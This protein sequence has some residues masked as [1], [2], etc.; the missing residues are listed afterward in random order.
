MTLSKSNRLP[1]KPRPANVSIDGALLDEAKLL[2]INV[3]QACETGLEQQ[4]RKAR[5]EKW[6]E[7][8]REAIEESNKWVEENGLPPGEVSPSSN[9]KV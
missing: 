7:E 6:R 4:V 9:A 2:G 1:R 3:S 8:N 5:A